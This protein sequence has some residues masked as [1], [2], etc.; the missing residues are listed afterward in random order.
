MRREK[1]QRNRMLEISQCLPVDATLT[2]QLVKIQKKDN[3]AQLLH[4]TLH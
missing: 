1:Q 2:K 3:M 4:V